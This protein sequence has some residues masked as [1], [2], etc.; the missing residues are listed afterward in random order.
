MSFAAEQLIAPSTSAGKVR[1]KKAT[2]TDIR[3]LRQ[4]TFDRVVAYRNH[5]IQAS[6]CIPWGVPKLKADP[7]NACSKKN[8]VLEQRSTSCT[9]ASFHQQR[10]KL[11]GQPSLGSRLATKS[12]QSTATT[13]IP[14][15]SC[16]LRRLKRGLNLPLPDLHGRI[17]GNKF[18]VHSSNPDIT[19]GDP[20]SKDTES[21]AQHSLA[22]RDL[23]TSELTLGSRMGQNINVRGIGV[24]FKLVFG[25]DSH[26]AV[27]HISVPDIR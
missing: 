21:T 2:C 25:G 16:P 18:T 19:S 3:V 9:G 10:V 8:K 23:E 27:P 5:Q 17:A 6:Q 13:I 7:S 24:F 15:L 12:T 20:P 4:D 22:T 14:T 11:Y 26:L 1:V